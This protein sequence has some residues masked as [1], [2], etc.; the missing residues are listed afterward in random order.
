MPSQSN[1]RK[2]CDG[3]CVSVLR[4]TKPLGLAVIAR[5]RLARVPLGPVAETI[6][7]QAVEFVVPAGVAWSWPRL[8]PWT[9]CVPACRTRWPASCPAQSVPGRRWLVAPWA[10]SAPATDPGALYEAVAAELQRHAAVPTPA[11][12]RP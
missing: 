10:C 3:R 11:G 5:L 7:R 8:S 6:P 4:T 1:P 2:T 12:V 9:T